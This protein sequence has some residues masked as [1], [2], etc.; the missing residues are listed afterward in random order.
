MISIM[1][2]IDDELVL[3]CADCDQRITQLDALGVTPE[4]A[5]MIADDHKRTKHLPEADVISAR[6]RVADFLEHWEWALDE[7]GRD[8]AY[9]EVVD[10]GSEVGILRASDLRALIRP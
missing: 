6:K 1:H 2:T 3:W 10:L 4:D 5:M 9:D 7:S 8:P